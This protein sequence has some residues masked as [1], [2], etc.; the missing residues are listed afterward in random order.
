MNGIEPP[1]PLRA[2]HAGELGRS[3]S[4]LMQDVAMATTPI[5]QDVTPTL[6]RHSLEGT[7]QWVN[8]FCTKEALK[9]EGSGVIEYIHDAPIMEGSMRV[10]PRDRLFQPVPSHGLS[11]RPT[12]MDH[13]GLTEWKSEKAI[14][15]MTLAGKQK[16][17][18]AQHLHNQTVS[19]LFAPGWGNK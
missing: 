17:S 7:D 8:S 13:G 18:H 16:I 5:L 6:R 15:K 11:Q 1:M 10:A 3:M 14:Y 19:R 4:R 2:T 9:R 12:W